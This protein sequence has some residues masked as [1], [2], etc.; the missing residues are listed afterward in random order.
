V[1]ANSKH[2]DV[3]T[4][5][6]LFVYLPCAQNKSLSELTFYVRSGQEPSSLASLLTKTVAGYDSGLPVYGIKLL[7]EQV[8]EIVFADRLL[9]SLSACLGLLAGF[10]AAIGLYGAMAY[11]VARR[12][13]EVG[14]RIALGATRGNIYWMIPRE[15]IH[16]AAIG[17]AIGLILSFL[18]GRMI[19]S[20]LFGVSASNPAV[21]L[22]IT[23]K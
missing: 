23:H 5:P 14:V 9:A 18:T 16:M 15:V 11:V 13:R 21:L 12:T 3:R 7:T 4:L 8:T 19:Q 6:R 17:L 10:L 22:A 2:A 20:L 1:V